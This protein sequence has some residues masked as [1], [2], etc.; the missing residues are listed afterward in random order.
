MEVSS[1]SFDW[2]EIMTRLL[3]FGLAF[4]ALG[5]SS[6]SGPDKEQVVGTIE[7]FSEPVMVQLPDTVA[8][9]EAFAATVR[10]YGGGCTKKGDTKVEVDDLRATVTPYDFRV[11]S[12][13]CTDIL[14][15]FQHTAM[16]RFQRAGTAEVVVRGRKQPG[17]EVVT[18]K[19]MVV[20]R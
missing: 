12:N 6:I 2:K 4:V 15:A 10:T 8:A 7:H 1:C 19:R 17:D 9:G 20:V 13:I 5:C 16:L 18:V 14:N 3:F 11:E